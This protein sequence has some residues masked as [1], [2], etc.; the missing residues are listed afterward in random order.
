MYQSSHSISMDAKGR[1]AIPTK[2]RELL[3][4]DC[5]GRIV[6]TAHTDERCLL[7]Y[8]EPEWDQ[9]LPEIKALPNR[10]KKAARMQRRLLGYATPMEVDEA[11]GRLLL[12]PTLREFAG[13]DKKLML[14]GM[15]NRY[16]LWDEQA[17]FDYL[18]ED[19]DGVDEPEEVSNFNV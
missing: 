19:D 12:P 7:I 15:L 16:E 13:L 3:L 11:N 10:N 4:A 14:V 5:G 1:L 2:V 18:N 6:V 8:P 9:K 17:W